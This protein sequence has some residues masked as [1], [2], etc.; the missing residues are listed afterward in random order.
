MSKE[1]PENLELTSVSEIRKLKEKREAGSNIKLPSGIVVCVRSPDISELISSGDIPNELLSIALGK[2]DA[3]EKMTAEG[4]KK[5]MEMMDL[6]VRYSLVSPKV[7][8]VDPKEGEILISDL[9][10][11]DKTYIVGEA[12]GEVGKLKPFRK[13]ESKQDTDRPVVQKISK[14]EAK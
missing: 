14:P 4:I 9:S 6:M 5:G 3:L 10:Q 8:D 1:K 2:D 13:T 11:E 7:V 12:Q